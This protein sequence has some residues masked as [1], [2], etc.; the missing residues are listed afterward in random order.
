LAQFLLTQFYWTKGFARVSV[1]AALLGVWGFAAAIDARSLVWRSLPLTMRDASIYRW[2]TM[3]GVPAIW[4]ALCDCIAFASQRTSPGLPSPSAQSLL[5]CILLG[6]AA[7][8]AISVLPLLWTMIR[9]RWARR[10][11]IASIAGY[12][13]WLLYGLP[14]YFASPAAAIA[15]SVIGL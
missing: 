11:G 15:I 4:I 13:L 2:W 9:G 14:A 10:I 5:L 3:A 1:P 7:L 6:W 8:G 12:A